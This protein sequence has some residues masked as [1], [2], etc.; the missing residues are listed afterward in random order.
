MLRKGELVYI[1]NNLLLEPMEL[2]FGGR[3]VLSLGGKMK[4]REG[5]RERDSV[6]PTNE[7]SP[8]EVHPKN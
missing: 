4:E 7:I 6:N 8:K 5:G 1:F 3:K 2:Q